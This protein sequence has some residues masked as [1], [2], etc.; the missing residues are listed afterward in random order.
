MT[1]LEG[2]LHKIISEDNL[3]TIISEELGIANEVRNTSSDIAQKI[4]CSIKETPKQE[5][6]LHKNKNK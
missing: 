6:E 3:K 2:F 4:M 1:L 5:E